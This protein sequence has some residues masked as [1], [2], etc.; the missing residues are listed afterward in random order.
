MYTDEQKWKKNEQWRRTWA[1][2]SKKFANNLVKSK[3]R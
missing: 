3:A 1:V 2:R